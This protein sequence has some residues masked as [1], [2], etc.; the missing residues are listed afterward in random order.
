MAATIAHEINNPL[1]AVTN[2]LF[3]AKNTAGLPESACRY[4]DMA[5]AE[6]KRI[7]Y[8]TRQSL[9][10]YR[11][12]NAPALTTIHELL[13]SAVELLKSRV[14]AKK[15]VI[16]KQWGGNVQI[17]AAGLLKP[18]SQQPGRHRRSWCCP[19]ADL[20]RYG[21]AWSALRP[22]HHGRQWRRHQRV[23]ALK[24]LPAIF[25]D[26]GYGWNR[27]WTVGEQADCGQAWRNHSRAVLRCRNPHGHGVLGGVAHGSQ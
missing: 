24:P 18:S 4:L 9:G 13:E 10:F 22:H 26:E 3:L 15:A 5:D 1:A 2:A 7:A 19:V 23:C 27:A 21:P 16:E 8:I 20:D 11:E 17:I 6:L 12:S 14:M 25:H